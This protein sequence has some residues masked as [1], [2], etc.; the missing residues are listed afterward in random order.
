MRGSEHF[1]KKRLGSFRVS[2]R[3][4]KE[5]E[6]VSLR[7]DGS[8]EIDSRPFH[9]DGGLIDPPGA[10]GR[11]QIGMARPF[12]LRSIVLD[13]AVNRRMIDMQPAFPHHFFQIT[14]AQRIA[15][16]PTHAQ[17]NGVSLKMTPF[18]GI[19]LDHTRSSF[20]RFSRF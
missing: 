5:I 16:V 19:L 18:E 14:L 20:A 13:P 3:T 8:V 7:I 2:C 1:K 10:S 12:Q 6:C 17:E 15:E 9:L 4:E 11:L